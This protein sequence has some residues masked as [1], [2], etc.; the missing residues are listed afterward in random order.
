MVLKHDHLQLRDSVGISPT[1]LPRGTFDLTAFAKARGEILG[2]PPSV[3]AV[4]D[5]P[6]R[7]VRDTIG[8]LLV[9]AIL[10]A[11]IVGAVI[12]ARAYIDSHS[13]STPASTKSSFNVTCCAAFNAADL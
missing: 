5:T 7:S 4:A 11:L 13:S 1:S 6:K 3:E 12:F 9:I 10:L 2:A 8:Q